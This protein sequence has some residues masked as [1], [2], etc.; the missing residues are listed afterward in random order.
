MIFHVINNLQIETFKNQDLYRSFI[1]LINNSNLDKSEDCCTG[2]CTAKRAHIES[3][4]GMAVDIVV[5]DRSAD[6]SVADTLA[7]GPVGRWAADKWVAGRWAV[8]RRAA[9]AG[10]CPMIPI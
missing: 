10:S 3:R 9:P 7:V 5:L 6:R 2:N 1:D 8:G 4:A